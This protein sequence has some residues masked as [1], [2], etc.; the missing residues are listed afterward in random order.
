MCDNQDISGRLQDAVRLTHCQRCFIY[1]SENRVDKS[2][3]Q[4][5]LSSVAETLKQ[6]LTDILAKFAWCCSQA[7]KSE[8]QQLLHADTVSNAP[9]RSLERLL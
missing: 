4:V 2:W 6:E 8:L 1:E 3:T 5:S 7:S 9:G